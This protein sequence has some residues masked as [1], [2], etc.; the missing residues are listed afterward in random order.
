MLVNTSTFEGF[1]NTFLQAGKYGV[2][3]GSLV[4][5]PDGFIERNLCGIVAHNVFEDLVEGVLG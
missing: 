3:I 1:P 2:P 5:D 4:V